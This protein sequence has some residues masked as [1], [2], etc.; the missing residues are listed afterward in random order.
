MIAYPQSN[1]SEFPDPGA[2]H[3]DKSASR[4]RVLIYP[5]G[6]LKGLGHSHVISTTDINGRIEIGEDPADSSVELTLPVESFEVDDEALRAEE[7]DEFESEVSDKDK[8]GTRR[9]MLGRKVLD[10]SKFSTITVRS[11]DWS[12]ELTDMVVTAKFTIKGQTKVVEFPASV[13]VSEDQI[14]VSGSFSVTHEQFALKPFS[15][16]FGSLRVRD[17]MEMK[18]QI[19]ARPAGAMY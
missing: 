8:R 4:L 3:I 14:V 1:A 12:G 19:T 15:A 10:S 2:Y 11:T 6:M 16:A 17:E 18:F 9:N 7:G 13:V 5:A